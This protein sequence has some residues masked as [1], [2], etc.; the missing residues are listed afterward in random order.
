MPGILLIDP[1]AD[2]SKTLIYPVKSRADG[3]EEAFAKPLF[4]VRPYI[5]NLLKFLLGA[6][7]GLKSII[8]GTTVK[9][10]F[11]VDMSFPFIECNR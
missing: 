1:S 3:V 5:G 2:I 10:G 11:E 7:S 9:S 4:D 6:G 8:F